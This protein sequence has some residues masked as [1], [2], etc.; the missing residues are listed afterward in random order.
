[1][2]HAFLAF[3]VKVLSD[4][5]EI[6]FFFPLLKFSAPEKWHVFPR[7]WASAYTWYSWPNLNFDGEKRIIF[8][9]R[10]V[11]SKKNFRIQDVNFARYSDF[12]RN[13][14]NVVT[15]YSCQ[16]YARRYRLSNLR[17]ISYWHIKMKCLS[18]ILYV[19]ALPDLNS[20]RLSFTKIDVVGLYKNQNYRTRFV[21][22]STRPSV[23][24][25]RE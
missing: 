10:K 23:M 2:I 1:M 18:R 12:P 20:R 25:N 8:P 16:S 5:Y 21:S 22:L 4:A 11:D 9:I 15:I 17:Q 19:V 13:I 6:S 14:F 3:S 24:E 7:P